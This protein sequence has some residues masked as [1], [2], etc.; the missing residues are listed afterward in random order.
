MDLGGTD[1]G[2]I[3]GT[4]SAG[5]SKKN[6]KRPQKCLCP[7]IRIEFL[8]NTSQ[9]RHCL[10]EFSG[11]GHGTVLHRRNKQTLRSANIN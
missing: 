11:T 9:K 7:K 10:S 2:V 4:A 8:L 6:L 5:R 3:R 1:Q